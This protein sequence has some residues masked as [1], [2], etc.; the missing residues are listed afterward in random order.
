FVA[1]NCSSIPESLIESELFGYKPGAFTGASPKGKVGLVEKAQNG[2]LF[3]DEIGE[4]PTKLQAKLLMLIQ[5]KTFYRIG[6]S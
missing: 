6:D 3:L 4:L 5:D 1:I 2:T